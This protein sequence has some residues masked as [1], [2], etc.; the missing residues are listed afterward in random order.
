ME[1]YSSIIIIFC[2]G[3][4]F[5]SVVVVVLSIS[6]VMI[7][8]FLFLLTNSFGY[9]EVEQQQEQPQQ[10]RDTLVAATTTTTT[11][12]IDVVKQNLSLNQNIPD[13]K[14]DYSSSSLKPFTSEQWSSMVLWN[15]QLSCSRS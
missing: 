15:I 4:A 1:H 7:L 8:S 10:L 12:T 2:S 6:L 11:T 14:Y 3:R 9:V 5:K 13:L